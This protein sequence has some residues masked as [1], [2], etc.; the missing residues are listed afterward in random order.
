L[1]GSA[2]I[3]VYASSDDFF[4][5]RRLKLLDVCTTARRALRTFVQQR[6]GYSAA[7]RQTSTKAA[8]AQIATDTRTASLGLLVFVP[9]GSQIG[10]ATIDR[11]VREEVLARGDLERFHCFWTPADKEDQ[12]VPAA[13]CTVPTFHGSAADLAVVAGGL[14]SLL[15][16]SL[17]TGTPGAHLLASSHAGDH[18]PMHVFIPYT[19]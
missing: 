14:F 12:L 19:P 17:A 6:S 5:S 3:G 9:P 11:W 16:H 8:L 13:G 7:I 4:H 1:S 10:P 2:W 18:G 15:G